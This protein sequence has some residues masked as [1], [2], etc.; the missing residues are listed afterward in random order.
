LLLL[1]CF[2]REHAEGGEVVLDLLKGRQRGLAVAGHQGVVVGERR[3]GRGVAA[4]RIKE[5]VRH[6]QAD[7][8][9]EARPVQPVRDGGAFES[10]RSAQTDGG[11][12]GRA[13]DADLFIRLGDPALSGSDV[14]ASF[15]QL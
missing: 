7:G 10:C 15:Q 6:G 13:S 14:R 11:I 12:I 9:Q 4:S 5:G 2:L 8:P 3:L 1:V